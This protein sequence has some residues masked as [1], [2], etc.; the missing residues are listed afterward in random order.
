MNLRY[1]GK[2]A[3]ILTTFS[4]FMWGALYFPIGIIEGFDYRQ[5]LIWFG[6]TTWYDIP[7]EYVGAKILIRFVDSMRARGTFK[8]SESPKEEPQS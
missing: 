7:A 3:V 4:I 1:F 5:W 2:E 6:V 8:P